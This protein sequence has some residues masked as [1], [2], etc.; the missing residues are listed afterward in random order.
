MVAEGLDKEAKL[1][2]KKKRKKGLRIKGKRRRK[3]LI[4]SKKFSKDLVSGRPVADAPAFSGSFEYIPTDPLDNNGMGKK[5]DKSVSDALKAER[6][7]FLIKNEAETERNDLLSDTLPGEKSTGSQDVTAEDLSDSDSDEPPVLEVENRRSESPIPVAEQ[8]TLMHAQEQETT[9]C[10]NSTS[11]Q[12]SQ[13]IIQMI[14][15]D[16]HPYNYFSTPAFQRRITQA[17][18]LVDSLSLKLETDT[19]LSAMLKSKPCILAALLDPCFKNS[20]EDF[21]PQGADLETYKQILAEEV[22]NYME[23]SSEVCH[24]A[25]SEASGS[26]GI[27]GAD[28]FTSSIREGTSSSGSVDSSAADNVAIG[29]KSFMFPSAM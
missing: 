6:G 23:S 26:S 5:R 28:S 21:F 20:L 9:Y 7:R 10:E 29:G 4:L 2:A 27:V 24:I 3:K 18:N 14:V 17:L 11:S 25:T 8:D 22:C 12:I 16:M 13:A 1:P 19:L 15:E